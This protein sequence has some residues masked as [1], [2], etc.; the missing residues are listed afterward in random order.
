MARAQK[1]SETITD[2]PDLS[3]AEKQRQLVKSV[4]CPPCRAYTCAYIECTSRRPASVSRSST[5]R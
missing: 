5:L 4:V 3:A 1:Q 2:N